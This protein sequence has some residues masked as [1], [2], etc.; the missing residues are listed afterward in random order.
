MDLRSLLVVAGL[1]ALC[2]LRAVAQSPTGLDSAKIEQLSGLKGTFIRD[3][4]VFKVGKPRTDVKVQI[5]GWP[6]PPFMGLGSWAAFT[7]AHDGQ[8]IMM[9]DTVVFEDEVNP[10]MSA[11][12]DAGLE[13]T[14][15]HN[16]FFF[17]EPKVYFMHIGGIGD[18]GVLAAGVKK[19]YDKIA[20]IRAAIPTPGKSFGARI[21]GTNAITAAPLESI[22]GAKGDVNQG[23]FKVVI[24]R[25]ATMHGVQVG[26][27]M[28]INTWASFGG[29]DDEA[30][31]DGDFA[32]TANELQ[33]VLKTMRKE[34]I[35]IVAIHQHMS[36][37][38]PRY[39]F[40]HYWGKGKA[41]D[42]AGSLKR[43]LDAQAAVK[44]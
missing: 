40:L 8:V 18:A 26:K 6:M 37:E 33:A 28:G 30:V 44:S 9:G 36:H 27:E 11:A 4:N 20:E 31:I 38:E 24:G 23:M 35:S 29:T 10:A 3:E 25:R 14:A 12:F 15:L 13:V 41:L 1:T 16:H 42:L 22:L 2:A 43:V 21:G 19:V 7:P 17:D 32:M 39:L 5:D 34:G